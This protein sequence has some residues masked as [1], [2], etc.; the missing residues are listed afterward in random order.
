MR[1][2][3]DRN[4]EQRHVIFQETLWWRRNSAPAEQSTEEYKG[5]LIRATPLPRRQQFQLCGVIEKKPPW[6]TEDLRFVRAD[7][8]GRIEEAGE[9]HALERSPDRRRAGGDR[10]FG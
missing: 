2:Q 5:F 7:R 10:L 8:F 6:R 4:K 1:G 9:L 3:I